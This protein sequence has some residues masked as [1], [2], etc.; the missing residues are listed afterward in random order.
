VEYGEGESR[1]CCAAVGYRLRLL[2]GF[3]DGGV[4]C[5]H[6]G[7]DGHSHYLQAEEGADYG[8]EGGTLFVQSAV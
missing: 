2:G 4:H 6:E 1:D 8:A 3:A 7:A 5:A